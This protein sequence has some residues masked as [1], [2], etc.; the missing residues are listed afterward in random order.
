MEG[1]HRAR[2]LKIVF[3]IDKLDKFSKNENC[4]FLI[5]R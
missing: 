1:L 5:S 2:F 3:N 4:C